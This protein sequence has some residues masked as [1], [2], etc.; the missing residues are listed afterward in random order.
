MFKPITNNALVI[1]LSFI[2]SLI[3][4][5]FI[6][7]FG[8]RLSL[9]D[10]PNERS[11]HVIPTPRGGGIG[12]WLAFII[13]GIF[14]A[15]DILFTAIAGTMGLLGFLED[16][17]N[18]SSKIRLAVQLGL[19]F[20][21]VIMFSG[22]PASVSET[23]LFLF[24][25]IF[26]TGST[27][28]YNFMDGI[29]GISGLTG[30]VGFG[31]LAFFSFFIEKKPDIALISIA[32]ASACL[33]FLPFNFPHAKVFMGDVGS[34][35]L[36]FTFAA[37]VVKLSTNVSIF[38]CLIMFLCTFYADATV[39]IF[40][41]WRKGENLM[42]AHRRHLYQY[43][44]NELRLPHWQVATLFSITQFLFGILALLVFKKGLTWQV[45]FWGIF[46]IIFLI[47]YKVVKNIRPSEIN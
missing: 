2:L 25:I 14:I 39:T 17:Y 29:N 41:R 13:V 8:H 26:I 28:F 24:W 10:K 27:N 30:F 21:A 33:G 15:K 40:Y 47:S 5:A 16:R 31:L 19:S 3:C 12:I 32:L 43:L 6:S 11:S 44:S 36:G 46:A 18:I 37:F 20:S 7:R 22:L 38:L 34:I 42:Q 23:A 1:F 45:S 35:L 9:T 4:S